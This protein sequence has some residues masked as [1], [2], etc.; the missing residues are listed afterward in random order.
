[1]T[2]A[3]DRPLI[4]MLFVPA[5]DQGK[6]AG[7]AAAGAD[8]RILDLEDSVARSAKARA[9][10]NAADE[11]ERRG[12]QAPIWVRV[13]SAETGLLDD[14]LAAVVRPGLAGVDMPKVESSE[15]LESVARQIGRLEGERGMA[16]GSVGLIATIETAIGLDRAEDIA[17]TPGRLHC[18][19]FGAGDFC[20]DIGIDNDP[21]SPTVVA[22]KV[23]IV[24]ASRRAGIAAP[25]D[26]AFVDYLD[27]EGLRDD[28]RRGKRIGFFGKHAIHPAQLPIIDRVFRPTAEE[29]AHARDV[30]AKFDAAESAGTA[31]IGVGGTLVDYPLAERARRVIAAASPPLDPKA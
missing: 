23:A 17:A 6:L 24:L 8:A 3:I 9:R 28:A 25:H 20:L 11:I 16:A 29:L 5:S 31:A 15:Q 1:M 14:D 7:S 26:S 27:D 18:L 12:T 30:V 2:T 13:N 10:H 21:G 22:A 4:T 19:G